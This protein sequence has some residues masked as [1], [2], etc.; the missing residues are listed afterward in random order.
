VHQAD[1]FGSP[2]IFYGFS[3]IT[4]KLFISIYS[5]NSDVLNDFLAL[6][7]SMKYEIIIYS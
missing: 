7:A 4:Y 1:F 5:K 3:C 6:K 2:F